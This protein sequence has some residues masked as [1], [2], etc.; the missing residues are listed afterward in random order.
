MKRGKH[1]IKTWSTT[2]GVVALS[3]GE[4]EFYAMV[5][6]ASQEPFLSYMLNNVMEKAWS[7][8]KQKETLQILV[9]L[10]LQ[11]AG[12]GDRLFDLCLGLVSTG[13]LC[14][15]DPDVEG[16]QVRGQGVV[17]VDTYSWLLT[18]L[19]SHVASQ[20]PEEFIKLK[21]QC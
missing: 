4:A 21:S 6:I 14:L 18:Q 3:S 7:Q 15:N 16:R 17:K 5:K 12:Q 20:S 1:V 19:C 9:Q 8:T 10:L 13:G 11:R 2:H